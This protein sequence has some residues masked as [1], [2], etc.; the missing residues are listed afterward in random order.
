MIIHNTTNIPSKLVAVIYEIVKPEGLKRDVVSITLRNKSEGKMCGNWGRFYSL[1]NRITLCVP[2]MEIKNWHGKSTI[3]RLDRHIADKGEWL[4]LI[5]GHE[6]MHAWQY[7]NERELFHVSDY[8][9]VGAERYESTAIRK[10]QAYLA[11]VSAPKLTLM[12]AGQQT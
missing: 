4:A 11:S 10:W 12:A 7:E 2:Q 5:I 1:E 3:A 8:I 6:A 9:E